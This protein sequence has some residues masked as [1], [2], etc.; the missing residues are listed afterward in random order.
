MAGS[1]VRDVMQEEYAQW[2]QGQEEIV[3]ELGQTLRRV[4][5][6]QGISEDDQRVVQA[7]R[8]AV[9]HHHEFYRVTGTAAFQRRYN[10]VAWPAVSASEKVFMWMGS[11]QRPSTAFQLLYA[12][13]GHQIEAELEEL[14]EL[15]NAEDGR[16]ASLASLSAHQLSLLNDLQ[17]STVREEDHIE[18]ETAKLQQSLADQPLGDLTRAP[19]TSRSGG[20]SSAMITQEN[21]ALSQ[22][23]A[24]LQEL[25]VQ[26]DA[27]RESTLDRVLELLHTPYQKAQFLLASAKLQVALR[28]LRHSNLPPLSRGP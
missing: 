15:S 12:L 28:N 17:T 10:L 3:Q 21:P 8:R 22:K 18:R 27:L 19:L 23:L 7:V 16:P 9:Q 11:L 14:L 2:V 24:A 1:D 5:E 20:G 13:M 4:T 6:G 26:A 25:C